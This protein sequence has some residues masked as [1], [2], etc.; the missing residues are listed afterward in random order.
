[1]QIK[2]GC[3]ENRYIYVPQAEIVKMINIAF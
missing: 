2:V 1:M 3:A